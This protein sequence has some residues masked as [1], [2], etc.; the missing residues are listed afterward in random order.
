[1]K[2]IWM[3]WRSCRAAQSKSL[4][5]GLLECRLCAAI[6]AD[7]K[8]RDHPSGAGDMHHRRRQTFSCPGSAGNCPG[9]PKD[10]C[11]WT[12]PSLSCRTASARPPS[13]LT[14]RAQATAAASHAC[15][16]GW[17]D[18]V[19]PPSLTSHPYLVSVEWKMWHICCAVMVVLPDQPISTRCNP[20]R[21]E[22]SGAAGPLL[23]ISDVVLQEPQSA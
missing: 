11:W 13:S 20:P 9:S 12:V 22:P 15:W 10:I 8:D 14:C 16:L 18:T 17:R 21:G 4:T 7:R 19:S 1:M 6:G 5:I 2:R 3:L 23:A